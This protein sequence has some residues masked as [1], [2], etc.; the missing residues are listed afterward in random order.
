VLKETY[1]GKNT[2]DINQLNYWHTYEEASRASA[3]LLFFFTEAKKPMTLTNLITGIPMKKP[4]ERVLFYFFFFIEAKK[5]VTLTN[6]ITGIP[7]K[8]PKER[9]LFTFFFCSISFFAH[10]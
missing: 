10:I 1:R 7:T 3:F 6:L 5:P 8:K 9:V 4:K 2:Y